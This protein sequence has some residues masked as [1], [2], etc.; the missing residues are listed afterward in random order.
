VLYLDA[1][2]VLQPAKVETMASFA[3]APLSL[4]VTRTAASQLFRRAD[5]TD[6]LLNNFIVSQLGE[7][8]ERAAGVKTITLARGSA[9]L[10][11]VCI[12]STGEALKARS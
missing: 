5:E 11:S 3:D 9:S 7:R 4:E 12:D 2:P 8:F 1:F 6:L 10:L